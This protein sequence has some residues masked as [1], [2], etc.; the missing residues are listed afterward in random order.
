MD[1]YGQGFYFTSDKKKAEIFGNNIYT[2]DVAYSTSMRVGKRTGREI[3]FQYNPET[4]YWV[5]PKKFSHHL[6]IK[7]V[8][9]VRK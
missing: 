5:I 6:K 7:S 2:V 1:Q 8:R 9:R 3:D 4:G